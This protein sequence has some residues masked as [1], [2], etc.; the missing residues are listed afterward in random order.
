M[1]DLEDDEMEIRMDIGT[2]V[3]NVDDL[4]QMK[5][6]L[7]GNIGANTAL[8]DALTDRVETNEGDI[9]DLNTGLSANDANIASLTMRVSTN[10][11]DIGRLETG[12]SDNDGVISNL[13]PRVG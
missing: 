4:D 11:N 8:I 9:G 1:G 10:E 6:I 13:T 3:T 2:L 7:E 5:D 12:V